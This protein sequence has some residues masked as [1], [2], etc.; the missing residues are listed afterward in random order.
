[1]VITWWAVPFGREEA[2]FACLSTT[3]PPAGARLLGYSVARRRADAELVLEIARASRAEVEA[4]D[5]AG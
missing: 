4:A 3:Q 5:Q 2:L 1:M